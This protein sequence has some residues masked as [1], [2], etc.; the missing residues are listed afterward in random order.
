MKAEH[1]GR[2]VRETGM[3]RSD[4]GRI[5]EEISEKAQRRGTESSTMAMADIYEKERSSLSDYAEH[6][7]PVEMQVGAVFLINGKV[8]GLGTPV[9]IDGGS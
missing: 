4:Q 2:S 1:V 3:F 7:R 5:W 6:F 8:V 9:S